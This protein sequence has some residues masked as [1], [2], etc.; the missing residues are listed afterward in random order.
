M[1]QTPLCGPA[2][3]F[4]PANPR[5]MRAGQLSTKAL[6]ILM[7][8]IDFFHRAQIITQLPRLPC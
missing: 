5:L 6:H 7:P 8:P 1:Q 4:Q 2:R 3:H